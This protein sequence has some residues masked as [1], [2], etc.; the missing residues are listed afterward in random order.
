MGILGFIWYMIAVL[1]LF[2]FHEG[3]D[4][5]ASFLK[6]NKI[7]SHWDSWHSAILVLAIAYIFVS[8]YG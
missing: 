4:M 1:P 8:I 3:S 7:Y 5:L 6:K 2:M